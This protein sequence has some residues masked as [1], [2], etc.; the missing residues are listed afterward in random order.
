VQRCAFTLV[1]SGSLLSFSSS[2]PLSPSFFSSSNRY[3][4]QSSMF[5]DD[6]PRVIPRISLKDFDVRREEI[7]ADLIKA[8]SEIGFLYVEPSLS[9]DS[10]Q[11]ITAVVGATHST[12]V[13]HLIPLRY[14]N[15]AFDLS[16]RFFAL[17]LETKQKTPS[18]LSPLTGLTPGLSANPLHIH[19]WNGKSLILYLPPFGLTF[20]FSSQYREKHGSR[21][22]LPS[23][24]FYRI[25]RSQGIHP[26]RVRTRRGHDQVVA[27]G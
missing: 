4:L 26:A 22:P 21:V 11:V 25:R 10:Q 1:R 9:P 18:V 5:I 19:R 23:S 13:D 27:V 2:T 24:S 3:T 8:S 14:I 17:P 15:A 20:S 16:A 12:L 6:A 7:K